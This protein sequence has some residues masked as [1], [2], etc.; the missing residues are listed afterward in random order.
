MPRNASVAY[1][2]K[3]EKAWGHISPPDDRL[4]F[5]ASVETAG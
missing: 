2:G 1:S 4:A 3:R 5:Y